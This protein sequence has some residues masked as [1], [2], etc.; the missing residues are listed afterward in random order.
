MLSPHPVFCQPENIAAGNYVY[1]NRQ[2][3]SRCH[4][5]C[6]AAAV[7]PLGCIGAIRNPPPV[8]P[9]PPGGG[10]SLPPRY[11]RERVSAPQIY[12]GHILHWLSPGA[13]RQRRRNA[14]KEHP[15]PA[16]GGRAGVSYSIG[17]A[18]GAL[19]TPCEWAPTAALMPPGS[20]CR[21]GADHGGRVLVPCPRRRRKGA[22]GARLDPCAGCC[23]HGIRERG[24]G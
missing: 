23:G 7:C 13:P 21:H 6:T 12:E 1:H 5:C 14:D 17:A 20:I 10:R 4:T 22:H 15:P 2:G 19:K 8:P 9:V 3:F 24:G 18:C 16:G 11:R